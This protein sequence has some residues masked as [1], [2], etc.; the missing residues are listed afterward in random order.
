MAFIEVFAWGWGIALFLYFLG[1][2]LG[3]CFDMVGVT[4]DL[5]WNHSRDED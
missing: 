4:D 5:A 2:G 1:W 3:H